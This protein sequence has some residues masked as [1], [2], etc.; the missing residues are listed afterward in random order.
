[1]G[2][3]AGLKICIDREQCIGDG[4]CVNEAP[5]TF[6]LDDEQKAYVLEGD[7]D[8]LECIIAAASCC[9]MDIITIENKATGERIYPK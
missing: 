8:E 6:E 2:D 9:P 1:M 5:Q 3:A 4:I 7:G